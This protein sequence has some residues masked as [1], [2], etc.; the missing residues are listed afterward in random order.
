LIAAS[1]RVE[2]DSLPPNFKIAGIV[3]GAPFL[4]LLFRAPLHDPVRN[5]DVSPRRRAVSATFE[6]NNWN[7][8][9]TVQQVSTG[10]NTPGPEPDSRAY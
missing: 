9:L 4:G 3:S 5:F 2:I 8:N 10:F 1:G 6:E 7:A